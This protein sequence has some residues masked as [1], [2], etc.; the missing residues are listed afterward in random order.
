MNARKKLGT[1][2][3]INHLLDLKETLIKRL[4]I[5]STGV[6]LVGFNCLTYKEWK[7]KRDKDIKNGV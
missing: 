4:E 6:K 2:E 5:L 7:T 1:S 3:K